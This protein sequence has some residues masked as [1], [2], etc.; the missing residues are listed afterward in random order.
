M[1]LLL[2]YSE[3]E[4]LD[5]EFAHVEPEPDLFDAMP[6]IEDMERRNSRGKVCGNPIPAFRYDQTHSVQSGI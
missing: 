4:E 5:Q 6:Y 1:R 3:I 2:S